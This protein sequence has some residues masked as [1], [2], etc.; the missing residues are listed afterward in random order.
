MAQEKGKPLSIVIW[1][2]GD[3]VGSSFSSWFSASSSS[4]VVH[5]FFFSETADFVVYLYFRLLAA[6]A[7]NNVKAPLPRPRAFDRRPFPRVE[8]F[9]LAL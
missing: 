1:F 9:N 6:S 5:L 7:P 3:V 8:N 4:F 2:V